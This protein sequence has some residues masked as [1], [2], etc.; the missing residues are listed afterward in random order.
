ME[1]KKVKKKFSILVIII[2]LAIIASFVFWKM[3]TDKR[4]QLEEIIQY[5]YFKLYENEKYGVIDT[6][7]KNINRAKIRHD[8]NTKSV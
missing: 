5:S 1:E 4:Y 2:I 8:N 6:K 7:R 3:Y